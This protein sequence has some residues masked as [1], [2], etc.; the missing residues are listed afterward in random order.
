M[1]KHISQLELVVGNENTNSALPAFETKHA[2]PSSCKSGNSATIHRIKPG[3][4][5]TAQRFPRERPYDVRASELCERTVCLALDVP[6]AS[7]RART[8]QKAEIALARQIA[9][10]LCHTIFS[11]PL[12]EVG[13][14]F[15]RDRSTVS[16]ACCVVEDKRDNVTFDLMLCQLEALLGV[17]RDAPCSDY[18]G[19]EQ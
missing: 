3:R 13:I 14:Q 7:I 16:H 1:Y 17:A 10:Y 11:I 2:E 4:V 19:A 9:M 8:R 15:G 12:A 18:L 5:L 6:L